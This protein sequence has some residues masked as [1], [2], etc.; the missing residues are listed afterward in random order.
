[1][2]NQ[3]S[4]K[5]LLEKVARALYHTNKFIR[6]WDDPKTIRLWHPVM[7]RYAKAAIKIIRKEDPPK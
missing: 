1:M 5:E 3:Q 7:Y 2:A 4:D 6:P